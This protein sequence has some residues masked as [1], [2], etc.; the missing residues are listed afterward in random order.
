[1][2][3]NRGPLDNSAMESSGSSS[4]ALMASLDCQFLVR[5]PA[6]PPDPLDPQSPF[7]PERRLD[8]AAV[9]TMVNNKLLRDM[10]VGELQAALQ[11]VISWRLY[12]QRTRQI[13]VRTMIPARRQTQLCR[14]EGLP[15]LFQS[16]D[17]WMSEYNMVYHLA[18]E[19]RWQLIQARVQAFLL[20][21]I[22]PNNLPVY[23]REYLEWVAEF[24]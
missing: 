4:D 20:D 9:N 17:L 24:L 8:L 16:E 6:P 7:E 13:H 10:T 22:G 11:Y 12:H 14:D 18:E 15:H 23:L 2:E 21:R 19:S 5:A 3:E 1:M